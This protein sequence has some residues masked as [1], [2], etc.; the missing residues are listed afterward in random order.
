MQGV[1]HVWLARIGRGSP[2][3]RLILSETALPFILTILWKG[4][5]WRPVGCFFRDRDRAKERDCPLYLLL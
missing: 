1:R 2:E 3:L 4:A 5:F